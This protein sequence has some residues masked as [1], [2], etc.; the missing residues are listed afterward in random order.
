MTLVG[1]PCLETSVGD[2]ADGLGRGAGAD[3]GRTARG[4]NRALF[5]TLAALD[6]KSRFGSTL[7]ME[8]IQTTHALLK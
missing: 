3:P 5:R 2:D 6:V 4:S 1:V 7:H 8:L